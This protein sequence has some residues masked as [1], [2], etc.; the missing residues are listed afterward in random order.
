MTFKR[1]IMKK[2]YGSTRSEDGYWRIKTNQ[3]INDMLKK[4]NIFG[5]IKKQRPN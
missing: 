3:K 5:F 4:Q 2:M 1:K